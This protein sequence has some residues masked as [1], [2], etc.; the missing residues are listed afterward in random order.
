MK[1]CI[2]VVDDDQNIAN[3]VC[4]HL[5]KEGFRVTYCTD[6]R[7]ALIQAEG[8]RNV[9]LMVVD[10]MMPAFGS[11]FDVYRMIRTNP[12]FAKDLPIV[13]MTGLKPEA[14]AHLV[15]KADPRV[16]LL[17]KP[18]T[19]QSLLAAMRE[20]LGDAKWKEAHEQER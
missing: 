20:L 17:H 9:A 12:H 16:R 10:V 2:L 14:V 7:Q 19:V 3:L 6:A 8:L 15:P 18:T 11:G 4:E 1:P 13:F 5:E